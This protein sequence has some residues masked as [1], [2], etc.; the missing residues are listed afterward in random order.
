MEYPSQDEKFNKYEGQVTDGKPH[1]RGNMTYKDGGFYFGDWQNGTRH[2]KGIQLYSMVSEL[3][4]YDGSWKDDKEDGK[5]VLVF[6]SGEN[7]EGS[8][9][10][11]LR[12]RKGIQKFPENDVLKRI[13]YEGE[14]KEDNRTGNG[15][16]IWNTGEKYVGEWLNNMRHEHGVQTFPENSTK[17]SYEGEW[18]EDEI[19]GNGTL[20]WRNGEKYVGEFKNGS[21]HRH[22]VT[23]FAENDDLERKSYDGEW[24]EDERSGNGTFTWKTG[25]K[26][27]GEFLNG[28]YHGHGVLTYP[29]NDEFYRISYEREW[30]YDEKS[31]NGTEISKNGEKYVGEFLDSSRHGHG[32]QIY[33]DK[34]GLNRL[35]YD[36]EWIEDESSGNGTLIWKNGDKYVGEFKSDQQDG[37]GVM[38]FEKNSTRLSY[39]GEWKEGK[40]SG[41]GTCIWKN[42]HKYVGEYLNDLRHGHGIVT[43]SKNS[44]GLSYE[45]GWKENKKSGKGTYTWRNGEKYVGEFKDGLQDGERTLYSAKN[46]VIKRGS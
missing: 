16:M 8:M 7:Y 28:L 30:K 1:G 41:N 22:G 24:K 27:F 32:V 39:E 26:Y 18:Q 38:T 33:P 37:Y 29:K 34:D 35:T 12:N 13:S 43:Y 36:G 5:G 2:G 15:T 44:T 10:K 14:W 3:D 20:I 23:I 40:K 31:G 11:G 6:K 46:K 17:V 4:I 21:Y 9:V 25:E 19:S 42:G 45:G